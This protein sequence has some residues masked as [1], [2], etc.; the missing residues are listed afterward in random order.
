[1]IGKFCYIPNFDP[2]G[3]IEVE[4]HIPKSRKIGCVYIGPLLQIQ[5][6]I[7][8]QVIVTHFHRNVRNVN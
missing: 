7:Y 5:S 6:H 4:L 1:M 3:P 2:A 8:K